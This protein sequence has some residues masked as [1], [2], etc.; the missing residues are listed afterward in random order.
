MRKILL[1]AVF[2]IILLTTRQAGAAAIEDGAEICTKKGCKML[3]NIL[4]TPISAVK[5]KKQCRVTWAV[6]PDLFSATEPIPEKGCKAYMSRNLGRWTK[7]H[8]GSGP[9]PWPPKVFLEPI[10]VK[11]NVWR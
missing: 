2:S 6:Q 4:P 9:A 7:E 10:P 1:L 3:L 11:Y 8:R 5:S